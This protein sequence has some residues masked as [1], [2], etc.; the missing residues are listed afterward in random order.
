M[1]FGVV[2]MKEGRI[3]LFPFYAANNFTRIPYSSVIWG[4]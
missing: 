1:L 3:R 4:C 2:V